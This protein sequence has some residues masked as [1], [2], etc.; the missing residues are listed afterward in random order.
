MESNRLYYARRAQQ[1]QRAAQRAITPQARAWH[2]QLAEDFAK[3]AQDF[4]GITAEAV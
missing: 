4:A 1:E 2:H 3:R